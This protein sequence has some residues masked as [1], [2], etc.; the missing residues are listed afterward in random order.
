MVY[1]T[2]FET[3]KFFQTKDKEFTSKFKKRL[4]LNIQDITC[5][6]SK[7][8][9]EEFQC[10]KNSA[11]HFSRKALK[12]LKIE[13][14]TKTTEFTTTY[15][16]YLDSDFYDILTKAWLQTELDKSVKKNKKT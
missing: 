4:E 7:K 1:A 10:A 3:E 6:H 11:K 5:I 8:L 9:I 2:L 13:N 16:S 14:T 15:L 12:I